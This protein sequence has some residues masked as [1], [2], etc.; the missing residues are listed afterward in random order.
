MITADMVCSQVLPLAGEL[1]HQQ[2]I[3]LSLL[4]QGIVSSMNAQLR[5]GTTS[6]DCPQD[7]LAAG[8]LYA[9]AALSDMDDT[10]QLEMFQ[11]GDLTLRKHKEGTASAAM[12]RQ[13]QAIMAPHVR[14]SFSFRGV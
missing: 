14:D 8:T 12:Y 1:S 10:N 13:A 5:E 9:L 11:A 7:F 6:R 2:Q 3:L 4:C